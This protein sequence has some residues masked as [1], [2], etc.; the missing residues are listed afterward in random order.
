MPLSNAE[1]QKRY[2]ERRRSNPPSAVALAPEQRADRDAVMSEPIW[3]VPERS[4]QD[5][6]PTFM[7]WSR[8]DWS[9]APMPLIEFFGMREARDGWDAERRAMDDDMARLSRARDGMAARIARNRIL[10]P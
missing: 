5:Q 9:A 1:R 7:G 6:M 3:P 8:Y 4:A 10:R 2:R